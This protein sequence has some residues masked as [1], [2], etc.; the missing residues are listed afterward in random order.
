MLVSTLVNQVNEH[1][2]NEHVVFTR[3]LKLTSANQ[4]G[5]SL[6]RADRV[7]QLTFFD[8]KSGRKKVLTVQQLTHAAMVRPLPILAGTALITCL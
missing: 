6:S 4:K 2:H 5:A 8:V 3:S 7:R 1:A